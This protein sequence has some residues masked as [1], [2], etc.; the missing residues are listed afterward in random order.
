VEE[1]RKALEEELRIDPSNANAAYELAENY[2]KAADFE[3][4]RGYFE[5]ALKHYPEFEN[6]LVG[7]GRTLIT[8]GRP[9]DALPYLHAAINR[10][11]ENEVAYYQIAN[12]YR[13]V[14]KT[15][16]QQKAL[17]EFTRL[18]SISTKR[19]AAVPPI[20]GDVTPQELDVKPPK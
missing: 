5:R 1:A 12:A 3:R 2:R 14:G 13:A 7:L 9:L 19:T 18:R 8:L 11:P 6:A 16:E 10:N 17:A 20:K 15:G 4:A